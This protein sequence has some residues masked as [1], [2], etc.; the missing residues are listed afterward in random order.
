MTTDN[1]RSEDPAEI[2]A[3]VAQGRLEIVLDRRAAIEAALADA[4]PATSS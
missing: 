2:A 1:P 4:G 3:Q